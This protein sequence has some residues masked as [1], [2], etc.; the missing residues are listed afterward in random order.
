MPW[1]LR[2]HLPV[3]SF[4][5]LSLGPLMEQFEGERSGRLKCVVSLWMSRIMAKSVQGAPS[6]PQVYVGWGQAG[7]RRVLLLLLMS[8][9]LRFQRRASLVRETAGQRPFPEHIAWW[10]RPTLILGVSVAECLLRNSMLG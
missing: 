5:V 6:C 3:P 4:L 1:I 9:P 8:S 2:T 7:V 10:E